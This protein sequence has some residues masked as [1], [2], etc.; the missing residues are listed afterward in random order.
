M[1]KGT[2][3][4]TNALFQNTAKTP[5]K[6]GTTKKHAAIT[7]DTSETSVTSETKAPIPAPEKRKKNGAPSKQGQGGGRPKVWA[8]GEAKKFTTVLLPRHWEALSKHAA[9]VKVNTGVDTDRS[10]VLR[11]LIEKLDNGEI[12]LK[13]TDFQ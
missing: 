5:A 2:G 6:K 1:S 9:L 13:A 4:Q 3:P 8:E 11:A 10:G 12:T 7:P